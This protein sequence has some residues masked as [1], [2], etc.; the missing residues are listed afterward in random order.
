MFAQT[1]VEDYGLSANY[2]GIIAKSIYDQ[3]GDYKTHHISYGDIDSTNEQRAL[4]E[5][6]DG[7]SAGRGVLDD[8][9]MHWCMK[10]RRWQDT[11]LY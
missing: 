3:L 4:D 9:A 2:H 8:N 6:E 7:H 5:D 10:W 1:V 11:I